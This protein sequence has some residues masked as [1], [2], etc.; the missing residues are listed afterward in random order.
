MVHLGEHVEF[1]F[2][3]SKGVI[4][5]QHRDPFGIVDYCIASAGP[6]LIEAD[7]DRTGHYRFAF[8]VIDL[9]PGQVVTVTAT[10]YRQRELR[11]IREIGE[12]WIRS[13]DPYDQPDAR[14][15]RDS[16]ALT[17]Y[18]S[19]VELPVDDAVGDLDLEGARLELHRSDGTVSTAYSRSR[20]PDGFE[21]GEPDADGV[22]IITYEPKAE[23]INKSGATYVKLIALDAAG[24]ERV[25]DGKIPTP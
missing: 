1:S 10:A 14:F 17:V 11:D 24:R 15:C 9:R 13:D 25:F 21:I 5:K 23:Q 3:I 7:L 19:V 12:T 6:E 22:R 18:K 16:V 2:G 8:D 20:D 4:V